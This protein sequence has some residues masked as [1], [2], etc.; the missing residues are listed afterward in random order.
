MSTGNLLQPYH[1]LRYVLINNLYYPNRWIL[2]DNFLKKKVTN[3]NLNF[4]NTI[5]CLFF[6]SMT[7]EKLPQ[8][9]MVW[10]IKVLNTTKFYK[11]KKTPWMT[12][13]TWKGVAPT[14]DHYHFHQIPLR[15]AEG[16]F[17]SAVQ[18]HPW[19]QYMSTRF[20]IR[21]LPVPNSID[22]LLSI[23]NTVKLTFK[24]CNVRLLMKTI[25]STG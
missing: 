8:I 20:T 1:N 11:Q 22:L 16:H 23:V 10:L 7:W 3:Y 13:M 18:C 24:W 2:K 21:T 25:A 15:F 12:A 14:R 6:F 5:S 9:R 4:K 17:R 19:P